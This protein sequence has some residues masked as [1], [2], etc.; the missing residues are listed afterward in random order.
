MNFELNKR[1]SADERYITHPLC[2]TLIENF[3]AI[4]YL[5][6]DPSKT[7]ERYEN[8]INSFKYDYRKMHAEE[9]LPYKESLERPPDNWKD[10]KPDLNL[11]DK[12]SRLS[13]KTEKNSEKSFRRAN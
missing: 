12:L 2:R 9:N 4:M 3:F 5:F 8:L 13:I 10:L 11:R 7:G 6:D 1:I